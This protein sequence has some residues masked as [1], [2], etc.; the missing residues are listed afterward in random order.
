[1]HT[2][3]ATIVAI[4][5]VITAG[6]S[7]S[8]VKTKEPPERV[9]TVQST[10]QKPEEP[11]PPQPPVRP[12][13]GCDAV[14]AEVS[15]YSGW[16]VNIMTAISRAESS[17]QIDRVGDKHLKFVKNGRQYGYSLS[18]LQVRILPGREHCD[19]SDLSVNVACAHKIWQGQG[20][21]AWTAYKNKSYKKYL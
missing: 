18:V 8:E 4:A 5:I 16:D 10:P 2:F 21:E 14:R 19:N 15:K 17:C 6:S 13:T 9:V 20:Y 7:V 11:I 3:A 1:M 12:L